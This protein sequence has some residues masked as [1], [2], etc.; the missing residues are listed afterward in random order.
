[1]ILPL[2]KTQ[3]KKVLLQCTDGKTSYIYIENDCIKVDL[4]KGIKLSEL[5]LQTSSWHHI[6]ITCS[7]QEQDDPSSK[8]SSQ[9]L[10]FYL[11]GNRQSDPKY[12]I[13]AKYLLGKPVVFIGNS[14]DGTCPFGAVADLRIYPYE[15]REE[16]VKAQVNLNE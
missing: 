10:N 9:L 11:D 4:T 16:E 12:P 13:T 1:M 5:K 7:E 15:L 3:D 6:A 2:E 14:S 8:W